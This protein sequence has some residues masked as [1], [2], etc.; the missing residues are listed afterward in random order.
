MS[1]YVPAGD[2]YD[3]M[4]YNRC[5]KSGIRLPAVSL[6]LWHNFGS[7]DNF[8]DGR[9]IV[10]QAFDKG[11]THFD[12]ANNYGPLPGSA[13]E[14]FGAILQKDFTGYL[15]D[16]LVISTKAG[17]LMWP[18][19]YG[20]WG[21]RKYVLSSLDQSLRRM[22]LDYVD[23]FYS[24]RP[25]PETPIEETMG[26]LDTAVRQ[27]KALY[28]GLSNY[29][30][31]QTKAALEV[32]KSLGTPCLIHQPKY[33]M[34]ERWVEGGLLD[35]LGD[36]GVG[37]IPFSPLAQGL[38]TDRYLTGIPEGSRASKPSGFLKADHIT[39]DKLDKI[40]RLNAIAQKRGQ[41]LA[42]MALAWLLKDKR[43]TSVLI[44]ASSVA[45][46]DN[47]LGAL[48]KVQFDAAELQEIES[49]LK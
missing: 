21:S 10:R 26:A 43:I 46:L 38:L 36:N 34:F 8:E 35:V 31:E 39:A 11:I 16:E 48:D 30:A 32:L 12:L 40:Q 19:P 25:D 3:T 7:I 1:A 28:V 9:Q 49:I 37:C 6:G 42:Q 29:S 18:G 22:K 13:E 2:R 14:N 47:N 17:Y 44:G 15:R 27:G 5:G 4:L 24:H 33:S 41:S 23:I 20:E 45:Q